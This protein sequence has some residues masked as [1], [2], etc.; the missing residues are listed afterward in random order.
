MLSKQP[1]APQ[2]I[3]SRESRAA[4][5]VT[6]TVIYGD[7]SATMSLAVYAPGVRQP[8]HVHPEPSLAILLCG[9]LA[10]AAGDDMAID[11]PS[12]GFK[13]P[14]LRHSTNF[15]DGATVLLSLTISD[16]A[17]W[18]QCRVDRW[19]WRP[20]DVQI[21]QLLAGAAHGR[22]CWPD[23]IAELLAAPVRAPALGSPPLW[24][25]RAREELRD[26]PDTPFAALADRAGVHRVH[27]SRSFSRWFGEPLTLFRLRRRT[28]LA[29][30][31]VLH[32]CRPPAAAA[33]GFAD[34]SHLSR[35]VRKLLGT[36]LGQMGAR[37]QA[38][39]TTPA[40]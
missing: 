14:G 31:G 10:E 40:Q 8:P 37:L 34:Q 18:T 25:C 19:G 12:I 20:A 21:R 15:G 2:M 6:K 13:P 38:F 17:L 32:H 16:A 23:V 33:A 35:N 11:R 9:S 4:P 5:Q 7:E 26:A 30:A 29:V 28:E 24:L 22:L 36:T 1:R 27:L 3:D 39:K